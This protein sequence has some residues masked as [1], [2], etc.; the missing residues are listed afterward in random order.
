[1]RLPSPERPARPALKRARKFQ[2]KPVSPARAPRIL[3][4]LIVALALV[5]IVDGL[6]GDGGLVDTIRAQREYAALETY[7]ERL[8]IEN[9]RLR[10]EARR[11]REDPLAIESIAREELNLIYPGETLFIITDRRQGR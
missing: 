11:L 5:I 10:E 8:R 2:P 7:V 3:R 6:V 9:A 1:M 4:Y